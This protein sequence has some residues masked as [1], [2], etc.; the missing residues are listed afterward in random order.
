[1][2]SSARIITILIIILCSSLPIPLSVDFYLTYLVGLEDTV[3]PPPCHKQCLLARSRQNLPVPK[4]GTTK[5]SRNFVST[6][7][8][9]ARSSKQQPPRAHKP[10]PVHGEAGEAEF[11]GEVHPPATGQA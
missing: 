2:P 11:Q 8:K 6:K 1:M 7:M 9:A 5:T 3:L 10:S 4:G